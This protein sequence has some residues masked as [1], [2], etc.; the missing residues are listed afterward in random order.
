[1]KI[2]LTEEQIEKIVISEMKKW[3]NH[4]DKFKDKTREDKKLLEAFNNVKFFYAKN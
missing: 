1:M 2:E 4:I 3:F